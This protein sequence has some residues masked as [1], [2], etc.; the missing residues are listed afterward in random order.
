MHAFTRE[1]RL[2]WRS[3]RQ[4]KPYFLTCVGTLTLVLGAKLFGLY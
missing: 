1:L 2:A 3:L 4:R